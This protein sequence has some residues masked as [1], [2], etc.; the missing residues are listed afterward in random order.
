[1]IVIGRHVS[2]GWK[3]VLKVFIS[4]AAI[5]A[6]VTP[7]TR[8][9]WERG[10]SIQPGNHQRHQVSWYYYMA[11]PV[12]GKPCAL[13]GSFSV[14]ILQYGPFPWKRSNP[15]IFVLEQSR[16]IQNLLDR[17]KKVWKLSF[18]TLKLPAEAKKIE[19]FPKF[20]R[21]MKK[22]NIFKWK[23]PEV[24]FTS[25]KAV[26]YNKLLT[27]RACSGR[28]GEYWPSVV[29]VQTEGS[30][31]RT[32]TTS[33]QYSPVRPS[34]SVSKRLITIIEYRIY[35]NKRRSQIS[36]ASGT[37]KLISAAPPIFA[38]IILK[39]SGFFHRVNFSCNSRFFISLVSVHRKISR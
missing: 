13:I 26:P 23:P 33:G 24:H 15:C 14:R 7:V 16:Q 9:V 29:F 5:Q 6:F 19:F 30:E 3:Q 2:M 11:N 21:W 35:L 18:F 37:K 4:A 1:M 36:A 38:L 39:L 25:R 22:T 17:E 12:V 27:N 32:V 8:L 20:Q 28:T 10:R 34:C 31:V